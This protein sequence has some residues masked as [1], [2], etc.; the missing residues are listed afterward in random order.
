[1]TG[2]LRQIYILKILL[3]K[4]NSFF[5]YSFARHIGPTRVVASYSC[6]Y[7]TCVVQ[8][9]FLF[10]R[11]LW[12]VRTTHPPRDTSPTCQTPYWTNIMVSLSNSTKPRI[13]CNWCVCVWTWA[14]L[15]IASC[16]KSLQHDT[17]I[18]KCSGIFY[19]PHFSLAYNL[20]LFVE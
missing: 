16:L 5:I 11:H 13:K 7:S 9:L 17:G 2:F 4:R 6:M 14:V 19:L 12:F 8:N 18:P 10:Q 15:Y 20:L 3:G 1:M